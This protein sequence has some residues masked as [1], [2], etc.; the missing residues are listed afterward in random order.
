MY[1][2]RARPACIAYARV[3]Y[4]NISHA[5]VHIRMHTLGSCI[6][7]YREVLYNTRGT[8]RLT[9]ILCNYVIVSI[10]VLLSQL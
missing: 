3:L 1:S 8:T 10:V 5:Q 2:I 4:G 9:S 6:I 7:L